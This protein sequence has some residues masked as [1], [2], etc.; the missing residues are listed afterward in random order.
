MSQRKKLSKVV[1][2]KGQH[3]Y[4]WFFSALSSS[5][6]MGFPFKRVLHLPYLTVLQSCPVYQFHAS[7]FILLPC[8]ISVCFVILLV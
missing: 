8:N 5:S 1:L 7:K 4:M 3:L 2:T 6:A